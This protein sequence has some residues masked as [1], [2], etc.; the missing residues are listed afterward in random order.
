MARSNSIK[1]YTSGSI[2]RE[3]SDKNGL[4][5][6][7]RIRKPICFYL[8]LAFSIILLELVF[9]L[10]MLISICQ[11]I[12]NQEKALIV[13]KTFDHRNNVDPS[14]LKLTDISPTVQECLIIQAFSK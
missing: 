2:R 7:E 11:Y 12:I 10:F 14:G 4:D 5:Y 8:S 1:K 13:W 6:V 3:E 9:V